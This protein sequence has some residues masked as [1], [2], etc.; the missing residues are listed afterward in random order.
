MPQQCSC[1]ASIKPKASVTDV[2]IAPFFCGVCLEEICSD[3][4]DWI[5]REQDGICWRVFSE[6]GDEFNIM[7]VPCGK[8]SHVYTFLC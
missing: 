3:G 7:H 4:V 1:V 8:T 2:Q 5:E 6:C